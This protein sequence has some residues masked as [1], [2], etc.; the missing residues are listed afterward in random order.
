[1]AEFA[2]E[3]LLVGPGLRAGRDAAWRAYLEWTGAA[4]VPAMPRAAFLAAVRGLP[5]VAEATDRAGGVPVG[6][7]TGVALDDAAAFP[8]GAAGATA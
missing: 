5:G 6:V 3:R 7:L 8:P 2:A 1:F 4:H